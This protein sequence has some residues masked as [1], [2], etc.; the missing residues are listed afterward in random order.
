M[1]WVI[2]EALNISDKR[3]KCLEGCLRL[4]RGWSVYHY[5]SS[6][7]ASPRY[8]VCDLNVLSS[9]SYLRKP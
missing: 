7:V 9:E 3:L 4:V 6:L 1:F 2:F 5:T 8:R